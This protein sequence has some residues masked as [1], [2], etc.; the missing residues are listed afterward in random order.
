MC[1]SCLLNNK[2]SDKKLYNY[3]SNLFNNINNSLQPFQWTILFPCHNHYLTLIKKINENYCWTCDFCEQTYGNNES[4]YYCSLCN[5]H[6]CQNC[7]IRWKSKNMLNN[8]I[9]MFP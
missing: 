1:E 3:N 2:L 4:F 6:L 9:N 8:N 5:F 7:V